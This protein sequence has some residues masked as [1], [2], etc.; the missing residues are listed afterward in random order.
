LNMNYPRRLAL[1]WAFILPFFMAS[2]YGCG[3]N[4]PKRVPV[5][6][7]VFLDGKPLEF[8]VVKFFPQNQRMAS[9]GIGR[10]GSFT[11]TTFSENDGCFMGKHPVAV[12][13]GEGI[14]A[15]KMKW[16]APKKYA[17]PNT[18]G[19]EIDIP[20]PRSDV[21]IKLTSEPGKKYPFVEKL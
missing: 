12:S 7:R 17:D 15:T 20:G 9:G 2:I 1:F 6:G 10:D 8:G 5:S 21:L 4:L 14:S 3:D 11:L 19:L 18:S 13:T 16:Y